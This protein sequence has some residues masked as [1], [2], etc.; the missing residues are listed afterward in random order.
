MYTHNIHTEH[1][2]KC[3]YEYNFWHP[4]YMQP[5]GT[6]VKVCHSGIPAILSH[7]TWVYL[8]TVPN[9]AQI[10]GEIREV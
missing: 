1:L 6:R 3:V 9:F 5:H 10:G 4:V 2:L 8:H 7:M